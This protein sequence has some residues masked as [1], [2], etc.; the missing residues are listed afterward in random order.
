[1]PDNTPGFRKCIIRAFTI[2]SHVS[3]GLYR[4]ASQEIEALRRDLSSLPA[5]PP[6]VRS[7]D[8]REV[9]DALVGHGDAGNPFGML[10]Q[11]MELESLVG[12]IVADMDEVREQT[13]VTP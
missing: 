3:L 4:Q 2:R 10:L 6:F 5:C 11:T 8:P 13:T 9:A 12:R 7:A 1:M